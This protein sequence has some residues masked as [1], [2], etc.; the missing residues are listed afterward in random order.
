MAAETIKARIAFIES[1]KDS[2]FKKLEEKINKNMLKREQIANMNFEL[3]QQSINTVYEYECEA[4]N[5]EYENQCE[6]AR[7][8]RIESLETDIAHYKEL[9]HGKASKGIGTFRFYKYP[10][11]RWIDKA[12]KIRK[13]I[14]K[15]RS[16]GK[17]DIVER[18]N[19]GLSKCKK[20]NPTNGVKLTLTK[21]QMGKDFKTVIDAYMKRAEK[22]KNSKSMEYRFF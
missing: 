11:I 18:P 19:S 3:Q 7:A 22:R 10:L 2:H 17:P 6:K 15:T 1:E 5:N 4:V 21:D 13:T 14:R 12:N 16:K 20:K 9:V 8:E